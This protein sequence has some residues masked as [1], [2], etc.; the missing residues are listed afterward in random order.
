MRAARFPTARGANG[1]T[2]LWNLDLK[3]PLMP[4]KRLIIRLVGAGAA[5]AT[6]FALSGC[7]TIMPLFGIQPT[8]G[9]A[10]SSTTTTTSEEPAAATDAGLQFASVF[11][12]MG[13]V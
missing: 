3:V 13:S 9:A 2:G 5:I 6:A 12:D 7:S 1:S 10:N 8:P 11:T 4:P